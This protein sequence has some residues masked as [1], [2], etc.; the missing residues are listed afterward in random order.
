M[1]V[2]EFGGKHL[3]L[4][5]GGYDSKIHIYLVP[6]IAHQNP[7]SKS[8]FKYKVSLPGHFNSIRDFDFTSNQVGN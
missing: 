5:V 4:V 8:I 6:T 7:E 3:M 2:T 1:G